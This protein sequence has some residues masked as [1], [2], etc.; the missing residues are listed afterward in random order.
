ME[1]FIIFFMY[2]TDGESQNFFKIFKIRIALMQICMRHFEVQDCRRMSDGG[3][4]KNLCEIS[5]LRIRTIYS[6]KNSDEIFQKRK[7]IEK[8]NS[9]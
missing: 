8:W 5:S 3:S 7:K 2:P 9:R 6:I 4:R 1:K